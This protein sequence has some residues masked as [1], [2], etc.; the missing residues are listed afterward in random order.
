MVVRPILLATQV[1]QRSS[2]SNSSVVLCICRQQLQL[3]G[4]SVFILLPCSLKACHTIILPTSMPV[5]PTLFTCL[6]VANCIV[7]SIQVRCR[8]YFIYLLKLFIIKNKLQ[9]NYK[10]GLSAMAHRLCTYYTC[11]RQFSM[12]VILML[13]VAHY[14][15]NI[16]QQCRCQP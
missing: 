11:I 12:Y 9:F 16:A 6:V 2:R 10:T 4:K 14:M 15:Y 3:L 5:L 8:L 1:L 7:L 13:N